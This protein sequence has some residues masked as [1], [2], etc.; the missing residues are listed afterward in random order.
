MTQPFVKQANVKESGHCGAHLARSVQSRQTEMCPDSESTSLDAIQTELELIT[1]SSA[2]HQELVRESVKLARRST[3]AI[4]CGQ[5]YHSGDQPL[6]CRIE[7][8]GI[9]DQQLGLVRSSLLPTAE[10]SLRKAKAIVTSSGEL[11]I[12]ATPIVEIEGPENQAVECLCLALNLNDAPAGPFLLILQL[13][14]CYI[15]RSSE[16]DSRQ[17]LDWQI[18][19]TAA[20]AELMAEIAACDQPNRAAMLATNRLADFLDAQTIAVGFSRRKNGKRTKL[21]AISGT[22]DIDESGGQSQLI[23]SVLN[24]TLV[25]NSVTVLPDNSGNDR[26]M[27]LAH[28]KFI[29]TNP[30]LRIVT[31]PLITT[32]GKILGAWLCVLPSNQN[33]E[34]AIRFAKVA[35]RFLADAL[36]VSARATAGPIKRLKHVT[37]KWAL[38]KAGRIT[39]LSIIAVFLLLAIPMPHRVDCP[40]VLQPTER[41]FAIAPHDGILMEAF[42]KTGDLVSRNQPVARMDD[43]E[44]ILELS[45][46]TAQ[47]ESA[48]KKRDVN[49]STRDAAATKI[50]EFEI[51]Q[52]NAKIELAQ[53][54]LENLIIK[55]ETNGIVLRGDLEDVRGAPVRRGDVL[56]EISP[57]EELKLEVDVPESDVA[58]LEVGQATTIVLD[59]NPFAPVSA[60]IQSIHPMSEVRNNVNVFVAEASIQNAGQRLKPGMQ[61]RAKISIGLRPVGWILFHRP[62]EKVF[63]L[64]R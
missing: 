12:I 20:I 10:S 3:N 58:Y 16:R 23:E 64:L 15:A 51:A 63:A 37:H 56:M 29:E 50:S 19:A 31:A 52:L 5:F 46:L 18:S 33:S 8:S 59:G 55:S 9:I 14:G 47:R 39:T 53:M 7:D 17:A 26:S 25:R 4:W 62:V 35:S 28:R 40:G 48:A 11:T 49:R 32:S 36:D 43:R 34:K 6:T 45:D 30:N 60:C 57:L 61:G 24:E 22:S 44:L 42:V 41:R 38:G 27:K 2:N 13:V 1:R 21:A 54:R